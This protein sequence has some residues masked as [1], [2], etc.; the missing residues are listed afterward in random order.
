M[1]NLIPLPKNTIRDHADIIGEA[2]RKAAPENIEITQDKIN[3]LLIH[4]ES[5][6]MTCWLVFENKEVVALAITKIVE[7]HCLETKD[8]LIYLLYGLKKLSLDVWDES[9][10]KMAV[11]GKFMGCTSITAFTSVEKI[12]IMAERM[13]GSAEMTYLSIPLTGD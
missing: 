7:D 1:A 8:L 2:F 4:L 11:Y 10:K 3:K 12:K 13:G 6:I 9:F 5:R